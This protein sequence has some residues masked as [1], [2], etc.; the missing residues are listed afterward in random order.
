MTTRSRC[1]RTWSR[2]ASEGRDR[3]TLVWNRHADYAGDAN[4]STYY[5]LS[6][7]DL[8]LY[9]EAAG[10]E[11]DSDL[12]AIDN[13]HQVRIDAQGTPTLVPRSRSGA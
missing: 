7:L 2:A 13:V 4:P 9:D 8:W 12:S 3:A 5:S 10:N 1:S 11:I 6:D